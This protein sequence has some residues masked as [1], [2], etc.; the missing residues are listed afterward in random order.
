[1]KV[2]TVTINT[3]LS[4]LMYNKEIFWWS[5]YSEVSQLSTNALLETLIKRF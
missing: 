5:I 1:M 2:I 4:K 3:F